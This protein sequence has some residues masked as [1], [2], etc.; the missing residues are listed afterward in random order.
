M[1]VGLL[2][3]HLY[4]RSAYGLGRLLWK[5]V[6]VLA[7][8]ADSGVDMLPIR[9]GLIWFFIATVAEVLPTVSG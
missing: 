4:E 9:K 7:L 3:K 8:Y 5:Q 6:R 2:S 1:L